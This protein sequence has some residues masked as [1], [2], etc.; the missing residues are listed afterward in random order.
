M[1]KYC[2]LLMGIAQFGF[3]QVQE[4]EKRSEND[5]IVP[6]IPAPSKQE[7]EE[8]LEEM[9]FA[10]IEQIPLFKECESVAKEEQMNCFNEQM[11][12]H[13]QKNFHYPDEATNNDVQGRVFVKFTIDKEGNI[14]DIK[15]RGPKVE[16][17]NLL[18]AEA[19]RIIAKLPQLK[20]GM[21]NGKNVNVRYV[22]PINFKLN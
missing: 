4:M 7:K 12:R 10:V 15:S 3:A 13:I 2:V 5:D 20:P 17:A 21:Q 1:K 16:G 11:N 9:P 22:I 18:I 19:E 8:I 6:V 14:T